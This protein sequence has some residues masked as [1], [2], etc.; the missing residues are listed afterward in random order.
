MLPAVVIFLVFAALPLW[1]EEEELVSYIGLNLTELFRILGTPRSV[2]AARGIE[3]WQDDVVFVYDEGDFYIY[4]DRVWQ[5]GLRAAR[6]INSG[7]SKGLVQ[8]ILGSGAEARGDS[9][10]YPLYEASWP[11][12]L[13]YDF[14]DANKVKAIFIY[15]TDL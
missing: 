8:L 1:P 9:V 3:E 10:F 14:D 6:G 15:R 2:Y 11:L 7:D 5:L 13:R 4:G 12:M